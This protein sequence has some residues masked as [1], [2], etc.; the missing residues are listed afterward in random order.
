MGNFLIRWMKSALGYPTQEQIEEK[1]RRVSLILNLFISVSGKRNLLKL[2]IARFV[3]QEQQKK[4][5]KKRVREYDELETDRRINAKARREVPPSDTEVRNITPFCKLHSLI[6]LKNLQGRSTSLQ[7]GEEGTTFRKNL[8]C[9][10]SFTV[11][12]FLS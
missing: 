3:V 2:I 9:R 10:F 5:H 1:Q 8:I 4:E 12:H 7:K 11:I 6:Q